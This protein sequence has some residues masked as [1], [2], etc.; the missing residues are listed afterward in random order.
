MLAFSYSP[1][2]L[3]VCTRPAQEIEVETSYPQVVQVVAS[4]C[5]EVQEERGD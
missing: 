1:V 3:A 4:V 2:L 5:R